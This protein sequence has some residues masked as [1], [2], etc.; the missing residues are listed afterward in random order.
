VRDR[1][2]HHREGKKMKA[3]RIDADTAKLVEN[4]SKGINEALY[5]PE[6]LA[7]ITELDNA[8]YVVDLALDVTLH[9][10]SQVEKKFKVIPTIDGILQLTKHDTEF[11]KALSI[12]TE[13]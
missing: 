4:L 10:G 6:V 2:I 8:G 13:E 11:L 12:S 7:A 3:D 9:G 5:S 1:G